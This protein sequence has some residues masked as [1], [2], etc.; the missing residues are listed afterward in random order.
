MQSGGNRPKPGPGRLAPV[1]GKKWCVPK[2]GASNAALQANIDYVC[3][4]GV[5]CKP[6]QAGGACFQPNAISSHASYVMNAFY[7]KSGRHDYNCDFAH[8]GVLTT[9]DPSK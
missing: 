4:S 7:Q 1:A 2:A 3:S 6:I 5:D 9:S 8:T